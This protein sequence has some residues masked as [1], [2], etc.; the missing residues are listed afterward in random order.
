Y[1][2]MATLARLLDLLAET[3]RR[4]SDVVAELPPV[5]V[6]H[7]AVPTPWERKGAVMRE[8]IEHP[9]PGEVV[10]IDGVK[11]TGPDGWTLVLPDP[12]YP[13]TH[14]WA[15]AATAAEAE[16]LAEE[17]AHAVEEALR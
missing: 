11:V 12:E 17:R 6:V 16:R 1:D 7:R 5:H 13:G 15:E 9:P 2:A 4:V 3:G 10:L 14:V 8:L